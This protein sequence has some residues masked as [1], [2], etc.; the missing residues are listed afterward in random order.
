MEVNVDIAWKNK[1]A[2][3]TALT[4]ETNK[5]SISLINDEFDYFLK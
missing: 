5:P 2:E 4:D 1:C 3:H